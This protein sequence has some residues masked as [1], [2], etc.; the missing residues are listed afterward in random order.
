MNAWT[1][2]AVCCRR[3][4]DAFACILLDI[5]SLI[6]TDLVESRRFRSQRR[7]RV[8]NRWWNGRNGTERTESGVAFSVSALCLRLGAGR[9]RRLRSRACDN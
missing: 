2:R 4:W 7:L 5:L 9:S 3:S 8:L 6:G 1:S